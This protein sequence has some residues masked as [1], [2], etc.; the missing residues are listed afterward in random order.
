MIALQSRYFRL[1]LFSCEEFIIA[2]R[3]SVW[4]LESCLVAVMQW[5]FS[6]L[7]FLSGEI[8]NGR[9][10]RIPLL[11]SSPLFARISLLPRIQKYFPTT[12]SESGRLSIGDRR[13]IECD[14]PPVLFHE[15]RSLFHLAKHRWRSR[16]NGFLPSVRSSDHPW[17]PCMQF[18]VPG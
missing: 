18:C 12:S 2:T 4:L 16:D 6:A 14:N 15:W 7:G 5:P 17:H 10:G 8:R 13:H 11:I 1:F 3:P 9:Q